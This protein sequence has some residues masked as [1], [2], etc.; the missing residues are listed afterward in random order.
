MKK[1]VSL[2]VVLL[3]VWGVSALAF[4][5]EVEKSFWGNTKEGAP[6]DLILSQM[7]MELWCN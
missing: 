1:I 5:G 7:I 4:A 6:I 3:L 2:L